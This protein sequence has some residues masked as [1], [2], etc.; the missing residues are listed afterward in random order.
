MSMA[1]YHSDDCIR[2]QMGRGTTPGMSIFFCNGINNGNE[3]ACATATA[4]SRKFNNKEVFA[5]FTKTNF[6]DN[7][8]FRSEKFK[9]RSHIFAAFLAIHMTKCTE[10]HDVNH[11]II[12]IAHSYGAVIANIA[13]EQL[14]GSNVNR[15]IHVYTFGGAKMIPN[16]L[17]ERVHNFMFDQDIIARWGNKIHEHTTYEHYQH[18]R[19]I[20]NAAI[21][22]IRTQPEQSLH[23]PTDIPELRPHHRQ[24]I[25]FLRYF[26]THTIT[27]VT[28]SKYPY[29]RGACLRIFS[30]FVANIHGMASYRQA[31]LPA[32]AT[33]ELQELRTT[34][35]AQAKELERQEALRVQAQE[36]ERQEALRVQAQESERQE[37]LR[38]QAQELER[39]ETLRAQAP[40]LEQ[41]P[42]PGRVVRVVSIQH[43]ITT[44][45]TYV[46]WKVQAVAVKVQAVAVVV[47]AT[48]IVVYQEATL[49]H[50]SQYDETFFN[51]SQTIE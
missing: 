25:K 26:R 51:Q 24:E 41:R 29:I 44:G 21:R 31:L 7:V 40:E 37:A 10:E 14:K 15:Q 9:E 43:L 33:Q 47:I 13:L 12:L 16:S 17:A 49:G 6:F 11:R 23:Q 5:F 42:L 1:L 35:L 3:D 34:R 28:R 46:L 39:Q 48:G 30:T 50:I 8:L 18:L 45:L 20:Q 38:A 22:H 27:I 19:K 4:I 2:H 36:L 32:I